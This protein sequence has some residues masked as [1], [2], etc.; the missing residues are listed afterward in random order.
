MPDETPPPTEPVAAAA[1][2]PPKTDAELRQL[3]QD[4]IDQKVLT[5]NQVP[6]NLWG[7]VF[8][9]LALGATLPAD[10]SL[11]YEYYSAA[12]PR[13]VNGFAT[14]ISCY[15]LTIDEHNRLNPLVA[16]YAEMKQKFA[17]G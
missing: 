2:R 5:T 14:F 13:A 1:V 6:M 11:V 16:A 8:L 12:T 3:A 15:Y 7:M 10:T 17:D 4:I 9:P